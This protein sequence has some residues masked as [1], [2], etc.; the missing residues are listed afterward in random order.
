MLQAAF[1]DQPACGGGQGGGGQGGGGQGGGG[2]GGSC[3]PAANGWPTSQLPAGYAGTG[4][5]VG[6]QAPVFIGADQNGSTDVSLAQF[7][8]NMLVVAF[9]TGWN[10]PSNQAASSA[11]SLRN[12]LNG[13]YGFWIID[14]LL[15]GDNVGQPSQPGD[16]S[17]WANTYGLTYPVLSG[18]SAY[19]LGSP[20]NIM[21]V[22]TYVILD[23]GLRIRDI[24]M[25][26]PGDPALT[27][28][29]NAARDAFLADNP[30]WTPPC[31]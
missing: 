12:Q 19:D 2:Q 29:V 3:V 31:P 28:A 11:E 6:D 5:A 17:D 30:G 24:I 22:P 26:Y 9:H 8:G 1:P 23:P 14:I 21:A 25:G 13:S 7:Y 15:E 20:Y 16:A 18:Q 10:G 4:Y 27:T